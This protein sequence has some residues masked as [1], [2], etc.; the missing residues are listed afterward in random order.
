MRGNDTGEG[1]R[2]EDAVMTCAEFQKVLP[3]IIE[4]GGN[5]DEEAHLKSCQVCSD[6]VNDL[7]YIAEQAKLLVPMMEPSP[8]VWDGIQTSLEREGLVRP[9]RGTGRF[10]APVAV[11]S[12]RSGPGASWLIALAALLLIAIGL[13]T[14]H[15][16]RKNALTESAAVRSGAPVPAVSA[17][18]DDDQKLLQQ[19]SQH[20]P[21]VRQAYGDSLKSVNAYIADSRKVLEKDPADEQAR[22]HL[23]SAYH[24]KALLY[25]MAL[26]RSLQ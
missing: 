6:L 26:S 8:Q 5:A 3:Y 18:D 20:G 10:P 22:D 2:G 23:L 14:Y 17:L 4:S 15:G 1:F 11:L 13:L 7:K 24:Q 19:V 21:A 12:R 16:M 25:E 9:A